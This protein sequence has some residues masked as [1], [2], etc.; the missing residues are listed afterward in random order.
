MERIRETID[1]RRVARAIEYYVSIGF[2]YIETPWRVEK[3]IIDATIPAGA[4]PFVLDTTDARTHIVGSAE[5]GFLQMLVDEQLPRGRAYVS[6]SPCFRDNESDDIHFKDFFKIELF[7]HIPWSHH[8]LLSYAKQFANQEG[9]K[10]DECDTDIGV[11]LIT[12]SSQIEI[13]SYGT[14][15]VKI[16][17]IEYQWSYGTGLAEPRFSQAKERQNHAK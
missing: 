17:G 1:W 7:S 16:D 5:S 12:A 13:G 3:R 9:L 10:V 14:R 4:V 2:C 8:A 15:S 11:D 6:A